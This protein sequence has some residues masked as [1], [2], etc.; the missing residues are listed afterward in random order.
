MDLEKNLVL[1][2]L[3]VMDLAQNILDEIDK[4]N[5]VLRIF[6]DLKKAFDAVN[7]QFYLENYLDMGYGAY[8]KICLEAT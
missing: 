4:G 3:S 8:H 2:C 7:H 5:V 6:L 1:N